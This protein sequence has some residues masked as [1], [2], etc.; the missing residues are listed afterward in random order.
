MLSAAQ[1]GARALPFSIIPVNPELSL[2][3]VE[4]EA[5]LLARLP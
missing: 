5:A 1:E 3:D 2:R 4:I